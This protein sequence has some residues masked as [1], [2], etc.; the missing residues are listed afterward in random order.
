MHKLHQFI[1]AP[2]TQDSSEACSCARSLLASSRLLC[3][4]AILFNDFRVW[5]GRCPPDLEPLPDHPKATPNA[6]WPA[7]PAALREPPGPLVATI[8]FDA[9]FEGGGCG[10]VR[11]QN[12]GAKDCAR[13]E[14]LVGVDPAWGGLAERDNRPLLAGLT[15]ARRAPHAGAR[16]LLF[17]ANAARA[18]T[19]VALRGPLHC[20]V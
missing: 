12:T 20:G 18:C 8:Q 15:L 10:V 2:S 17:K 14:L 3:V 1:L 13:F 11:V 16:I 19:L 7:M 6:T 9:T 5:E 4:Q